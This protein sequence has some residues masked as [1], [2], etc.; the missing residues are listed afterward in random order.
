MPL[1]DLKKF[2]TANYTDAY[3]AAEKIYLQMK[4]SINIPKKLQKDVDVYIIIRTEG[5]GEIEQREWIVE[6]VAIENPPSVQVVNQKLGDKEKL[7][8][9]QELMRMKVLN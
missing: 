7:E 6:K 5:A 1:I 4:Y 9:I 2:F 3:I 8:V